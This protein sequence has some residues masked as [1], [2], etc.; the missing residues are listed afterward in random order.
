M[1]DFNL[2]KS[3]I[4]LKWVLSVLNDDWITKSLGQTHRVLIFLSTLNEKS[5]NFIIFGEQYKIHM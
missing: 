2:N 5:D 3:P 4:Y 1:S